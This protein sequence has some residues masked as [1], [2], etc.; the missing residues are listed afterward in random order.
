MCKGPDLKA[1]LSVGGEALDPAVEAVGGVKP[2]PTFTRREI[3]ET[4]HDLVIIEDRVY[5]AA[6]FRWAHPGGAVFVAMFG[7]RDGTLAFQSYH[8]REFPHGK[9]AEYPPYG[10]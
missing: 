1:V 2:L 10:Y 5:D 8:M 4:R 6:R 3:E 7:G 9:M